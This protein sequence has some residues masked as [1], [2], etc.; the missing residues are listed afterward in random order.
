MTMLKGVTLIAIADHSPFLTDKENCLH[1]WGLIQ[2]GLDSAAFLA[3][4]MR[5]LARELFKP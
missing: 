3:M 5:P 1:T 2:T 4:D